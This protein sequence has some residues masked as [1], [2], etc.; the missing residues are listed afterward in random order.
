MAD[1]LIFSPFRLPVMIEQVEDS[2][3]LATSPALEG[4][5]VQAETIEEIMLLAPGVAKALLD[6]MREKGVPV[7]LETEELHFPVKIDVLIG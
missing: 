5:L 7:A 2:T 3:Y 1:Q 4:F 6:T